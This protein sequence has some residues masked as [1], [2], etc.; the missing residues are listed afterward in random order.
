MS[1]RQLAKVFRIALFISIAA[2]LLGANAVLAQTGPLSNLRVKDLRTTRVTIKWD[3]ES[4][5]SEFAVYYQR[6]GTDELHYAGGTTGTT[7]SIKGLLPYTSYQIKVLFYDEIARAEAAATITV[8][9]AAK[10]KEPAADRSEVTPPTTCPDLPPMVAVSGH[11]MLT[12]CRMVDQSAIG[13]TDVIEHDVIAAVDIWSEVTNRVEVCFRNEGTLVFLD[14]AYTPR[15]LMPLLSFGRDG[16]TCGLVNRAGTVV[17]LREPMQLD[18]PIVPVDPVTA[19]PVPTAPI[20]ASIVPL[21]N[22]LIKLVETLFLRAAPDGEIIGLVWQNSEV[23][24]FEINGHWYKVEFEGR[25]GYISRY[26]R[27]VLR[28][29]CG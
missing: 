21:D 4:F 10:S 13:R 29:G 8:R 14:A 12:Q 26:F 5:I 19:D 11:S 20:E 1:E 15:K 25:T 28:G 24:V 6:L 2:M 17:L 7:F 23:P 22:C 3:A 27:E 18:Q 9:T 16:M